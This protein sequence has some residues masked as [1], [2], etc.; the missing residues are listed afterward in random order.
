M[1]Q[2]GKKEKKPKEKK[3][4]LTDQPYGLTGAQTLGDLIEL[5]KDI[6][7]DNRVIVGVTP[8]E[9]INNH[10][11]SFYYAII[12]RWQDKYKLGEFSYSLAA[13]AKGVR[14]GTLPSFEQ[15]NYLRKR[16]HTLKILSIAEATQKFNEIAEHNGKEE[17][18]AVM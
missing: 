1:T 14:E 17:I 9:Y 7:Q 6:F 16:Y 10:S 18:I 15:V 12:Y 3:E 13:V 5:T 2:V 4:W 8:P 11:M